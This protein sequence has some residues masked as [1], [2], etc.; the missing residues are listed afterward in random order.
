MAHKL[1][2]TELRRQL[3]TRRMAARKLRRRSTSQTEIASR[4]G[5]TRS[6][7]CW[8]PGEVRR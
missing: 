1:P 4:L 5:A 6:E 8:L 3:E 2:G 7:V